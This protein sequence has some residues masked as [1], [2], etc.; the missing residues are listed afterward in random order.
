MNNILRFVVVCTFV[1][2]TNIACASDSVYKGIDK[3]VAVGDV[4]GD[5]DQYVKLLKANKLINKKLKWTG[6]EIHLVQLGD[7]TDRGPDSLKIIEHLMKLEKQEKRAGGKVHVLI[8]N[9][10]SMNIQTDLR[11]VHPGEYAALVT[12]RS[13]KNQAQYL[14]AVFRSM[15][16][17]QPELAD[18]QDATMAKL[19]KTKLLAAELEFSRMIANDP[20]LNPKAGAKMN[21]FLAKSFYVLQDEA[22]Y[23][24]KV[25]NKCRGKKT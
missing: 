3:V 23:Q 10:E 1:T 25:L 9:H 12:R 4:H 8:G 21:K 20:V 15:L 14:D 6:G 11:Y 19:A 5:Y 7:V 2:V 18:V 13:K 24:K 22:K 17:A 16:S